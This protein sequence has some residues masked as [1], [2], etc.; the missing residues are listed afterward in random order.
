MP[1]TKLVG[2]HGRLA[3]F[4]HSQSSLFANIAF[5]ISAPNS[6]AKGSSI[7]KRVILKLYEL[8]LIFLFK[9]LSAHKHQHVRLLKAISSYFL[10]TVQNGGGDAA[11]HKQRLLLQQKLMHFVNTLHQYVMDRVS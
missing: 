1:S 6:V 3:I 2:G 7:L 11:H 10:Q 4:G 9:N 8:N 5:Q